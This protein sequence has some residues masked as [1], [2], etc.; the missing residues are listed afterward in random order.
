MDVTVAM[1]MLLPTPLI[2]S[3]SPA[4]LGAA[5]DLEVRA[6]STAAA[7]VSCGSDHCRWGVAALVAEAAAGLRKVT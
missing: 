4:L 5:R 3:A 6:T 1:A 2:L 7:L